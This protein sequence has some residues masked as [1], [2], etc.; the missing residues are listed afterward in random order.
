LPPGAVCRLGTARFLNFG[1][2]FSVA[3][4]PDGKTL[5]AG[6]W[7]ES[8]RLWEISSGKELRQFD[9]QKGPARSVGFSPDGKLL[10]CAGDGFPIVLWDVATAKEVR[11]LVGFNGPIT[12][13]TFSPD[14]KL[15]AS[16]GYDATLRL[17]DVATGREVRRLGG[18]V[19]EP[20]CPA[21][22]SPDG[23]TL[24]SA[25]LTESARG[26]DLQ[27]TFRVWEVTTG[28]PIRSFK[29]NPSSVGAAAFSPDGKLL[30]V[31]TRGRGELRQRICLWDVESGKELPPIEETQ[32]ETPEPVALLTFSPDGRALAA[33][34]GGPVQLWELATRREA[35]RFPAQAAG[36]I[37]LAFSPDGRLLASGST[38]ITVL[39]WDVTGRMRGGR[40]RPAGLSPQDLQC[41]WDDLASEDVPKAWRALWVMVAANRQSVVLLQERLRP[42]VS[43]AS[44]EAI[45][46]LVADLDSTRF[47]VRTAAAARLAELAELAEPA[48]LDALRQ[49]PS[50]ELRQRLEQVLGKVVG[51]RSRPSGERLRMVRAV[52]VLEQVGTPEARRL[53][54]TLS[55]GAPGA[56][57]TREA[58][59]SMA[60]LGRQAVV[61]R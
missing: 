31:A 15:V 54:A 23:R 27:R 32:N 45:D 46:R 5:A 8:V 30:A 53:L 37:S 48:L 49:R 16:K 43:A 28:T 22:F 52:Q 13:V 61:P 6:S 60:R 51:Q 35:C 36:R 58:Q 17:W 55:G 24:A 2:V 57:L 1:R 21:V 56:V 26:D 59:A 44:R 25:C 4:S 33:G 18:G 7:D 20:D 14:G 12:F 10:T 34:G 39:L 19:N 42:A 29:G 50:L 3:F 47:A 38:D 9:K 11:R 41:L 40:S